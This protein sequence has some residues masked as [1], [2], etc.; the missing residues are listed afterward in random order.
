MIFYAIKMDGEL[1]AVR[2]FF[3]EIPSMGRR[4][5]F[6]VHNGLTKIV[7]NN[8]LRK[9]NNLSRKCTV[10]KKKREILDTLFEFLDF[11]KNVKIGLFLFFF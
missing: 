4:Y 1:I 2:D 6:K 11:C 7:R 9:L 10:G 3:I 8:I 5:T